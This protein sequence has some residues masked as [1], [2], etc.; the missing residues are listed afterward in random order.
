MFNGAPTFLTL[1][2]L[3]PRPHEVTIEPAAG[4]RRS[5]TGLPEMPGGPHRYR[6]PDFDTLVDSPIVVG[7]PAVYEFDGR[8]QEAL[9]GQ[10]GRR[11]ASSTARAPRRTSRRSSREHRRMW[12]SLPY[13]KYV[14]FNMLTLATDGGGGLEHKNSTMLMASRWATRTRRPYLS[15][16]ELASHEYFHAWNVK[17]LRPV[18]LGPFDYEEEDS[19]AACGSPKASPTTTAS[20]RCIAPGCRRR[21]EYLDALSNQIEE[22]QTTPGRLVQPVEQASFDAWIKYYRPDENIRTSRSAT[23]PRAR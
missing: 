9:P 7:N 6:A 23:T 15:W 13:D 5:M 12:G 2:D 8:R 1:A 20:W 19:H 17:R 21:E 16:L 18:E 22:L 10:R 11:P 4:W 14:F 3:A